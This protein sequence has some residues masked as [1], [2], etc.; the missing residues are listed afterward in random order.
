MSVACS[1]EVFSPAAGTFEPLPRMAMQRWFHA[2][3][4][5]EGK[6]VVSGGID[7]GKQFQGNAVEVYEPQSQSWVLSHAMWLT[8]VRAGHV[9]AVAAGKLYV[10]GGA[11]RNVP[12]HASE[13]SSQSF[14]LEALTWEQQ[15]P[16][17][18]GR[19]GCCGAV[20]KMGPG[21]AE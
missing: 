19:L 15:L 11:S 5:T 7:P 9:A 2:A 1:A 6:V 3:V 17:R 14:D 4:A 16:M 18:V 8:K 20:L 12:G 10:V 13:R 21:A